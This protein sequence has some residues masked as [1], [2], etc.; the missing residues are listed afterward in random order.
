MYD[1]Y[2]RKYQQGDQR[3]RQRVPREARDAR[4]LEDDS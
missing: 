1:E 2:Q 3:D 4:Q